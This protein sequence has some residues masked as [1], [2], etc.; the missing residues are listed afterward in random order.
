MPTPRP[1][2]PWSDAD[3]AAARRELGAIFTDDVT[4]TAGLVVLAADGSRIFERRATA[5]MTPASTLK[6][7]VAAS[8]LDVLGPTYRFETRF[9]S[10]APPE[11][12]TLRDGIWLVGGGDPSLRSDDLE[13]GVGALWR[14]GI[15]AIDGPLTVDDTAF[16]GPE[17]NPRWDP[18]DLTYGYA[19]GTSA[20][21]LDEDTVEFDVT[22]DPA[23]GP[24]RVRAVPQNASIVF[25]G[26][27][28]SGGYDTSVT[29]E[30]KPQLPTFGDD[31]SDPHNE[32]D[33][34][35]HIVQGE[36]QK[37]YKPVLGLPGYVGG[38]VAS[39]FASRDIA[40]TGG[41]RAG[42]APPNAQILWSH[43]SPPLGTLVREMLVESNNHTA[44]QLLR[45]L[46]ERAGHPGTDAA[47]IA[48]E[49]TELAKFHVP[50][51]RMAV[52]DGSGLAPS[53]RIMPLTLAALLANVARSPIGDAYVRSLPLVGKEGT[54]R[55][56]ELHDAFGRARAK[57]GHIE[58][59]NAL[60]GSVLTRRH[61]R[62]AFA[63]VVNDGRANADVVY[64]NEDRALDALS[65]Y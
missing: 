35:G 32:F 49:K 25:S 53:D 5:P 19:A 9:V 57:S 59:V 40:L 45:T 63:F 10:S 27:I 54:V 12:G 22:P 50:R 28:R 51:D 36:T 44:E 43:P 47:G 33:L 26:S 3:R 6:L 55:S 20:I 8:A 65:R 2:P 14:S 38:V 56:H 48:L 11:M 61:G 13:R 18:G 30:R 58:N 24:A 62:V 29:I 64:R 41:Y 39:M 60:A 37:Y 34:D 16:A 17:Q 1:A 4:A 52:Y 42:A 31:A 15:K 21:S 46:G 7:V 23:G